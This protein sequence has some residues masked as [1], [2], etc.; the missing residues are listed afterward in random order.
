MISAFPDPNPGFATGIET[1]LKL[2]CCFYFELKEKFLCKRNLRKYKMNWM[3]GARNRVKAT[4]EK[5]KQREFFQR[6]RQ[7]AVQASVMKGRETVP[8]LSHDLISFYLSERNLLKRAPKSKPTQIIKEDLEKKSNIFDI[9]LSETPL[10]RHLKRRDRNLPQGW[11]IKEPTETQNPK[12][13]ASELFEKFEG[14]DRQNEHIQ[15]QLPKMNE[16]ADGDTN[17]FTSSKPDYMRS[18]QSSS[19]TSGI[20]ANYLQDMENAKDSFSLPSHLMQ[21][22]D[23]NEAFKKYVS[24]EKMRQQRNGFKNHQEADSKYSEFL[25]H[26]DWEKALEKNPMNYQKHFD[27]K[28]NKCN[29]KPKYFE[30]MNAVLSRHALGENSFLSSMNSQ[31]SFSELSKYTF[32]AMPTKVSRYSAHSHKSDTYVGNSG[33][34]NYR[35]TIRELEKMINEANLQ[36]DLDHSPRFEEIHSEHF[37]GMDAYQSPF[38]SVSSSSSSGMSIPVFF[39]RKRKRG[40]E[41]SINN[42]NVSYKKVKK[43]VSDL[44]HFDFEES[45][46][47]HKKKIK[48]SNTTVLT[49]K[50]ARQIDE[51]RSFRYSCDTKSFNTSSKGNSSKSLLP[52][53]FLSYFPTPAVVRRKRELETEPAPEFPPRKPSE[54]ISDACETEM[55]GSVRYCD[56]LEDSKSEDSKRFFV[57]SDTLKHSIYPPNKGQLNDETIEN[58]RKIACTI[59]AATSPFQISKYSES[60][61]KCKFSVNTEKHENEFFC[62]KEDNLGTSQMKAY[63]NSHSAENF[64]PNCETDFRNISMQVV[65][66]GITEK[67]YITPDISR[68]NILSSLQYSDD[69]AN[70]SLDNKSNAKSDIIAVESREHPPTIHNT[71]VK[72]CKGYSKIGKVRLNVN[73]SSSEKI[74]DLLPHTESTTPPRNCCE[75]VTHT[76]IAEECASKLISCNS[77]P[78]AENGIIKP[79]ILSKNVLCS[80]Q[81]PDDRTSDSLDNKPNVKNYLDAFECSE[82]P[83]TVP[84]TPEKYCTGYSKMR[85]GGLNVRTS[86]SEEDEDLLPPTEPATPLQNC[87]EKPMR[88]NVVEDCV[89]KLIS[90]NSAP[91]IIKNGEDTSDYVSILQTQSSSQ[92]K[93]RTTETT[94]KNTEKLVETSD[95]SRSDFEKPIPNAEV[96][97]LHNKLEANPFILNIRTYMSMESMENAD[98][99]PSSTVKQASNNL[100]LSLKNSQNQEAVNNLLRAD[101]KEEISIN[102]SSNDHSTSSFDVIISEGNSKKEK[103][104]GSLIS[105][106][107]EIVNTVGLNAHHDSLISHSNNELEMKKSDK[108]IIASPEEVSSSSDPERDETSNKRNTVD[109]A[110]QATVTMNN[111]WS[112]VD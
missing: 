46:V 25:L 50:H 57:N 45:V 89:S 12:E 61:S 15:E 48:I 91:K 58:F 59:D 27:Y 42:C 17:C 60:I 112:Q 8:A 11:K 97:T 5:K 33:S 6:Q 38:N 103:K 4:S 104:T 98:A 67:G 51:K 47:N 99:S 108:L 40:D 65:D 62:R 63:E 76:H 105:P 31:P 49:P 81:N 24:L 1:F 111:A 80:I 68:E 16:L 70:D 53:S 44:K 107:H 109:V 101:N 79:V 32:S 110:V 52:S 77:P 35:N 64:C 22:P 72:H 94:F 54:D 90:C 86:N 19:P 78:K 56:K 43:Y 73:A 23:I 69:I 2:I 96:E 87:Y 84:N 34:K 26:K 28:S 106:N 55:N 39:Q 75:K 102:V 14:L 20:Q 95:K 10:E 66:A 18:E 36:D 92:E 88:S 7:N 29:K 71:P 30:D 74:E 9:D 82:D 41:H 37:S 21:T 3:G 83:P 93:N 13:M 85:K 100:S